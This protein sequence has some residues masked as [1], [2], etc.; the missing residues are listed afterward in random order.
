M[1]AG[2][3][4]A[5][6]ALPL[7]IALKRGVLWRRVFWLALASV[8][9]FIGG[10]IVVRRLIAAPTPDAFMVGAMWLF[11]GIICAVSAF[12]TA[13]VARLRGAAVRLD[14]TG[15]LDRRFMH[16]ALPW[17]EVRRAEIQL[18]EGRPAILG[19]WAKR[20]ARYRRPS[21]F[22]NYFGLIYVLQWM[23]RPFRFAPISI[24]LQS[25]DA[26]ADRIVSAVEA[27]WGAP[28]SREIAPSRRDHAPGGDD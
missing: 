23:A 2:G 3:E 18:L 21:P 26:P 6:G 12:D 4:T 17:S 25:L 20:A 10:V 13:R 24:D 7:E 16:S 5:A 14:A 11:V 27:W 8:G 28:T 1:T 19:L 9:L 15:A 22:W